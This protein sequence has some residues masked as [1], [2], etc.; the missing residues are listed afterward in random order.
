MFANGTELQVRRIGNFEVFAVLAMIDGPRSTKNFPY[1]GE[2]DRGDKFS[3]RRQ[4]RRQPKSKKL[5]NPGQS[6]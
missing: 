6:S 3:K 5:H 2:E 4:R 1:S